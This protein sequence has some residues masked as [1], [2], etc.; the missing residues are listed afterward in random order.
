M[1]SEIRKT[2]L[3][4]ARPD[5]VFKALTDEKELLQWFPN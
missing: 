1:N 4:I 3:V 5:T 2:I